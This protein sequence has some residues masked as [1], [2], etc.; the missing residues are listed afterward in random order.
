MISRREWLASGYAN[1]STAAHTAI[2]TAVTGF[3]AGPVVR[4]ERLAAAPFQELVFF[5][6]G[7]CVRSPS[8][9]RHI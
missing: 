5:E 4:I 2:N 9:Y 8:I 3:N 6:E 7:H 1:F